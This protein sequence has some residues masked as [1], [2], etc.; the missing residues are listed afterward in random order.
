MYKWY[1]RFLYWTHLSQLRCVYCVL[2][3]FFLNVVSFLS[4]LRCCSQLYSCR[5]LSLLHF[6]ALLQLYYYNHCCF[7]N[8]PWP[9]EQKKNSVAMFCVCTIY[10]TLHTSHWLGLFTAL[11]GRIALA[12]LLCQ[13]LVHSGL[14]FVHLCRAAVGLSIMVNISTYCAPLPHNNSYVVVQMYRKTE[15]SPHVTI[16]WATYCKGFVQCQNVHF[17]QY[18]VSA[19]TVL[20]R[21]METWNCSG[22]AGWGVHYEDVITKCSLCTM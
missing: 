20:Q 19:L 3:T 16:Q 12:S 17:V 5:V 2:A 13:R 7:C 1:K 22:C 21:D 4:Q 15:S 9:F 11:S 18:S 10:I 14:K 8:I 6:T